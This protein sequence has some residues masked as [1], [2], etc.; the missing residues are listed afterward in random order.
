MNRGTTLYGDPRL[1]YKRT[2]NQQQ[3]DKETAVPKLAQN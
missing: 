3:S 1:Y 2:Q